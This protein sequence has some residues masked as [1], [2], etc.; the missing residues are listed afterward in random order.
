M[1]YHPLFLVLQLL[2]EPTHPNSQQP[3]SSTFV[4][5][6]NII[7]PFSVPAG[8]PSPTISLDPTPISN[9]TE[10]HGT[11]VSSPLL[12][13]HQMQTKSR[14]GCLHP[15]TYTGF[16]LFYST[17]HPLKAFNVVV[18][19]PEPTCYTKVVSNPNWRAAMGAEFDTLFANG[20]WSL[21]PRPL[22]KNVIRNKWVF[23]LKQKYD[24]IIDRYKAWLVVK[25]FE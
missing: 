6:P 14:T 10:S 23:K 16:Q 3:I 1:F 9:D 15:K 24:R 12:P 20:T 17:R 11:T 21:C 25:G 22:H 19:P 8:V 5:E 2:T 4:T 13:T 7:S 18:L